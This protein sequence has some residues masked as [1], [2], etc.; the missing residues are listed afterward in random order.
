MVQSIPQSEYIEGK[1]FNIN[2]DKN[3][4]RN[5]TNFHTPLE[6]IDIRTEDFNPK[7]YSLKLALQMCSPPN[8]TKKKKK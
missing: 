1:E 6:L 2:F 7:Q 8:I 3:K 4:P 5:N